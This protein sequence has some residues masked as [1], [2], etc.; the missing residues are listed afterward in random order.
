MN[1]SDELFLMNLLSF[2]LLNYQRQFHLVPR[3]LRLL[4]QRDVAG[5]DSGAVIKIV[6]FYWVFCVTTLRTGTRGFQWLKISP[7]TPEFV[8]ASSR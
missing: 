3:I 4:G 1:Y 6:I 7:A 2:C 8:Q 5:K